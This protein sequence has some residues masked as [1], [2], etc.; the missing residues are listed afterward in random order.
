MELHH[1]PQIMMVRVIVAQFLTSNYRAL[2]LA[3][4]GKAYGELAAR[5][6]QAPCFE[7]GFRLMRR[8]LDLGWDGRIAL[9]ALI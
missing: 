6:P 1:Q 8:L 2:G 5:D 4:S 9:E 3:P 7:Q